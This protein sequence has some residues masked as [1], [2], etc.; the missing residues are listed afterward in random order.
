MLKLVKEVTKD[1]ARF[2]M[3]GKVTGNFKGVA[4]EIEL[5]ARYRYD[6]RLKRIDWLGMHV[7]EHRNSSPQTDGADVQAQA[8]VQVFPV[9]SSA[10]LSDARQYGQLDLVVERRELRATLRRILAFFGGRDPAPAP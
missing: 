9:K 7:S 3:S 1:V 8:Q 10:A 5:K 6:R 2:E 4:S